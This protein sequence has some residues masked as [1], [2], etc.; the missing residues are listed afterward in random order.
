M[1]FCAPDAQNPKLPRSSLYPIS[2]TKRSRT[3][4]N[5]IDCLDPNPGDGRGEWMAEG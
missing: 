3:K 4:I 5:L 1:L 2:H